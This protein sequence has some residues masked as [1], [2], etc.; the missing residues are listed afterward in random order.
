M[1]AANVVGAKGRKLTPQR[2]LLHALLI[3]FAVLWLVPLIGA[4][5]SSFRPFA[6]TVQD[7]YSIPN[8]LTLDNYRNAWD[9]GDIPGRYWNTALILVPALVLTLFFSSMVAFAASRFSLEVQ[10]LAARAVHRGQPAAPAD[11]HPAVVP[12]VQPDPAA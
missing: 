6:E 3:F 9:Q 4:V 5:F 12:D 10:H 8:S 1:T 2:V 7:G 11:H